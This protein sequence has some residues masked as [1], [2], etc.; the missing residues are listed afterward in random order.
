MNH[1]NFLQA[2]IA[3]VSV[4][5][6]KGSK[7]LNKDPD[8]KNPLEGKEERSVWAGQL[9]QSYLQTYIYISTLLVSI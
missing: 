7:T 3:G 8:P 9:V 1:L 4:K 5:G 6:L 2:S